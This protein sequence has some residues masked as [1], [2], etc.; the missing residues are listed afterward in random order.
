VRVLFVIRVPGPV[1]T[2]VEKKKE[3]LDPP[4]FEPRTLPLCTKYLHRTRYHGP[5]IAASIIIII[6]IIIIIGGTR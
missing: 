3:C 6:I 5:I 1:W 2:G 4:E